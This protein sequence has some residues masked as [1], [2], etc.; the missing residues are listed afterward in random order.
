MGSSAAQ[1]GAAQASSAEASTGQASSAQAGAAQAGA[2]A[3]REPTPVVLPVTVTIETT[4]LFSFD[5]AVLRQDSESKLDDLVAKLKDVPYGEISAVGFADPIGTISYN[6][7]LSKSR[8]QSV[9]EYLEHKGVP[10]AKI[11]IEGRGATQA[12]AS[13]SNCGGLRREPMID[14]LQPDRR[15]EVTVLPAAQ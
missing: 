11:R 5:R 10:A 8:A 3:S 7:G 2:I 4:P 14:C 9:E 13:L 6:L 12:Y 1:P 15:V